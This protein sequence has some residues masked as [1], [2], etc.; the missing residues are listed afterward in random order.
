MQEDFNN[1][2]CACSLPSP[3]PITTLFTHWKNNKHILPTGREEKLGKINP[4]IYA[5]ETL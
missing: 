4:K 1:P 3:P 2:V 5:E